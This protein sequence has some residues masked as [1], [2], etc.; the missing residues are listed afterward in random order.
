MMTRE[1]ADRQPYWEYLMASGLRNILI[2]MFRSQ[3]GAFPGSRAQTGQNMVFDVQNYIETHIEE[4]LTLESVAARFFINKFHL[5]HIFSAITGY[6]FKRY[7]IM[8]RLAKAKDL[9]LH[10]EDEVQEIASLCG[11]SSASN[12]IRVFRTYEGISPLQYRNRAKEKNET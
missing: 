8:A 3:P 1:Y 6:T 7:V 2:H 10:T 9:L 5:S 12:F 4:P 11:F